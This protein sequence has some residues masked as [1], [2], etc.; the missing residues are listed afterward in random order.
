MKTAIVH[1]WLENYA[2]S[3]RVVESL[4]NT[5]PEADIFSIIDFLD[6]NA[7]K[8]V[9][10]GKKSK[11]SFI[12][13]LPGAKNHFRNYLALFPYAVEQFD[14]SD[15]NIVLSSSH[16]FV[17]GVMTN[18]D[19]LHICYC[20]SPIRYAWDFYSRYLK[21]ANLEKG[22]KGTIAKSVLHYIRIWDKNSAD[23]PDFLIAN[24]NHIA[25][26]IRK[27]YGRNSTVIY[28]PVDVHKFESVSEKENYYV[29]ASRMVPYKR[30][31][32]IVRAFSSM[33]DKRLI[34]IGDGPEMKRIKSLAAKNIEIVGYQTDDNLKKY[35][36]KAK[37]F[38]FA[39][40]E[41]FGIIVV[42]AMACGTPVIALNK[43]GV[44]ESVVHGNT[45]IF[46][47]EQSV[48]SIQEA[49]TQFEKDFYKFDCSVIRGHAEKFDRKIFETRIS[50]FVNQKV[51]EFF[52]D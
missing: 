37:A 50:A 38:V 10:K 13:N 31:D 4:T 26:R 49:V 9:L 15:Y 44:A 33:P 39:A 42:E 47:K 14:L 17:K 24:S 22:I 32:L 28:P 43:G 46:F 11:N 48:E 41:D 35:I 8:M 40:V 16:S 51:K 18:S 12:Q 29:T 20:H 6:D 34:V 5:W 36:Q 27:I 1:D 3:E 2:G 7:R 45:G 23:R 21:D 52:K 30:I 25:N 19:Q